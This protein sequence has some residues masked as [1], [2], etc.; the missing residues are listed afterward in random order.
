[1]SQKARAGE[2]GSGSGSDDEQAPVLVK[3][4]SEDADSS[5][6]TAAAMTLGPAPASTREYP[7]LQTSSAA[8]GPPRQPQ[9]GHHSGPAPDM[10]DP[11]AVRVEHYRRALLRSGSCEFL[12]ALPLLFF[13]PLI[14]LFTLP[15]LAMALFWLRDTV[16]F[17]HGGDPRRCSNRDCAFSFL[18]V[19][20][21]AALVVGCI[22]VA[23]LAVNLSSPVEGNDEENQTM[24]TGHLKV[25]STMHVAAL[26]L[27]ILMIPVLGATQYHL[28]KLRHSLCEVP[29]AAGWHV[30]AVLRAGD[31]DDDV[32]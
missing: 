8:P 9:W 32:L 12:V 4:H 19:T 29:A 1:M 22:S 27:N 14:G 16:R 15:S 3:H 24:H 28:M 20:N 7:A 5:A 11:T 13:T 30:G 18:L 10:D 31:S 23:T 25:H 17:Q 6:R 26:L 2:S 21:W